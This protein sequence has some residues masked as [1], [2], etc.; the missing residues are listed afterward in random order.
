MANILKSIAKIVGKAAPALARG[1][2][3]PAGAVV[4][5]TIKDVLGI[6]DASDEELEQHLAQAN[7]EM[8]LK[9]RE[10]E[11]TSYRLIYEIDA[12]DR[13]S[14]RQLA[15][16]KGIWVQAVLSGFFVLAYGIIAILFFKEMFSASGANPDPQLMGLFGT[17]FGVV[18][19][20][21]VQILNFWF[22]S[23]EGSRRKTEQEH[24]RVLRSAK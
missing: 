6:P 20:A 2:L 5:D 7:P 1:V 13:D 10:L 17:V 3:G 4:V 18:S 9:L 22:G 15:T 23:S 11:E 19:A 16:Q 12:K 21:I 8:L 24:Q 14:A